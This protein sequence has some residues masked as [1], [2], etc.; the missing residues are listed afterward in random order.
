M[1]ELKP[2]CAYYRTSSAANIDGDSSE[3]QRLAINAYA[4]R[5][6]YAIAAEFN[7]LAV[8]GSDAIDVREGFSRL[9]GWC[10][11]HNV[12]TVIVESA[13]RFARDL[14]VQE[15]GVAMLRARGFQLIAVDDPDAFAGDTPTSIMVRQILGAVSQFEKAGLVAKLKGARERK[16]AALGALC[17][18]T[19]HSYAAG[20][21]ELIA[22]A[23]ALAEG[24]NSLRAVAVKLAAQ[25]YVTAS[26]REFSPSQVQR[27][28]AP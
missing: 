8:K 2:A 28:V 27:L 14:I 3:R 16:S 6:G 23:K 10:G 5:Q 4:Q 11:E 7:D 19:G 26:G 24:G 21:P 18:G 12:R 25:G 13:S 15:T 1:S 22:T 9:L 17:V 20:K